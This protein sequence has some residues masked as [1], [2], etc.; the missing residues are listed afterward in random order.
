MADAVVGR[1]EEDH[2]GDGDADG[3][4]DLL[5]RRHRA[6][7]RA[8]AARLHVREHGRGERREA[9]ADAG[10]R[11]QEPGH[12]RAVARLEVVTHP[13][14]E[15][16]DQRRVIRSVTRGEVEVDAGQSR[17]HL[18]TR[19]WLEPPPQIHPAVA[20]AIAR[21][22]AV[23]IGPGSFYT[24]IMPPL[25]VEGV[26]DALAEMRGPVILIANLLTEGAGMNGFTA[27]DA[28]ERLNAAIGRPVDMVIVNVEAPPDAVLE[29]YGREQKHPLPLGR[30][31]DGCEVIEGGFWKGAIARHDRRRLR[32][33]VWA[34]LVRLMDRRA[35]PRRAK[36]RV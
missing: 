15:V 20:D 31:P 18:I 9:Q 24:S 35:A 25:L 19:V 30:I 21:F 3:V 4:A 13:R 1:T 29:R 28:I 22:D 26:A 14:A 27:G 36:A 34:S 33:A 17:G 11:Q 12:E 10:A 2:S 16:R 7:G 8:G 5:H 23:T 6:R 32:A